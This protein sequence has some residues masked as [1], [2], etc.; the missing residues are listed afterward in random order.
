M[1]ASSVDAGLD[2]EDRM[3]TFLGDSYVTLTIT[4]GSP[5]GTSAV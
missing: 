1:K 5:G 3:V 4:D 2:T